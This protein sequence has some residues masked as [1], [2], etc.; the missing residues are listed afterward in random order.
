MFQREDASDMECERKSTITD[1]TKIFNLSKHETN[2][3]SILLTQQ[4]WFCPIGL[5]SDS[6]LTHPS[7]V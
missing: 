1:N 4:I 7:Y 3:K 6:H 2:K 5:I